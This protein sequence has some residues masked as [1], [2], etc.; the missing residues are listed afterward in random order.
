[1]GEA[2]GA[3]LVSVVVP[4]Y[5]RPESLTTAVESVANQTYGTVELIVVDDHSPSPVRPLLERAALSG[6]DWQCHRHDKNRGASAAR[7]TGIDASAGDI[8]AFLDDD[9]YWE[10]RLVERVVDRFETAGTDVGVVTAGARVVDSDG[11]EVGR[12]RPQFSGE[13]TREILTGA[14]EPGTYSRIAVRREVVAATGGPD[15]RFPSWQDKEWHVRLSLECS[16]ASLPD[17]LVVRRYLDQEQITDD[18]EAKRDVSY[19]LLVEKYEGLASS[20]G[21]QCRRQFLGHLNE[22][23]GFSALRNGYYVEALRHLTWAIRYDP[24]SRSSYVFLLAALGGPVTYRPASR[25]RRWLAG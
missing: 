21:P 16:Y 14:V 7:Q 15:G 20:Y 1:M 24:G 12:S 10:P 25:L 8:V 5:G 6:V 3:P 2:A 18:F 23:L 22:S 13:I 17:A 11:R 4:T 9:D 19:P